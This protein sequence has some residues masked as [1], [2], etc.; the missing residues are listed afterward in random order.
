MATARTLEALLIPVAC[1]SCGCGGTVFC[2]VCR[3][4]MRPIASPRC[5][6]CGQTKDHWDRGW[7]IGDGDRPIPD[8]QSPCGFCRTWPEALDWADSAVWYEHEAKALVRALKYGGWTV[9][10]APMAAEMLRRIPRMK[11]AGVLVPV[12]LGRIRLRERGHNQA[13][14]I[15]RHLGRPMQDVLV[16]SR[17]T[18]TQTAL[19]PAERRD[20]VSGAFVSRESSVVS[21]KHVVLVD[22]VLT[23]GATLCAAAGA[24]KAAG[25]ASVG[26]VTFARAVKPD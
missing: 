6:R 11:N 21:G 12:P 20:N 19:H 17:E 15:A 7:R 2:D 26:A 18:K 25:A 9:A 3:Y 14:E 10:A 24:L 22:D 16:R 13:G 4:A 8:P 5:R 1:L 23:T